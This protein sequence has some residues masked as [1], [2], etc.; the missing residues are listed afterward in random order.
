MSESEKT[1]LPLDEA[2]PKELIT[3]KPQCNSAYTSYYLEI[4][5]FGTHARGG[6]IAL[7]KYVQLETNIFSSAQRDQP[8]E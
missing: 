8:N 3:R 1:D 7:A 6:I 5:R 2:K 4:A